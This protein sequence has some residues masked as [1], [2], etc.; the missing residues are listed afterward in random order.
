METGYHNRIDNNIDSS[1]ST[2]VEDSE[3]SSLHISILRLEKLP[4]EFQ[5]F[6]L[7]LSK[8]SRNT[9]FPHNKIHAKKICNLVPLTKSIKYKKGFEAAL[10]Q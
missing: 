7:N 10:R 4:S 3:V 5:W 8:A 1:D 9:I 6:S 2:I